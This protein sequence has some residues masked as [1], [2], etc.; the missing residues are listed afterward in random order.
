V[1]WINFNPYSRFELTGTRDDDFDSLS[2]LVPR[3]CAKIE[4]LLDEYASPTRIDIPEA[5]QARYSTYRPTQLQ[6][7]PQFAEALGFRGRIFC[8]REDS[9]TSGSHKLNSAIPE[10]YFAVQDGVEE[11]VVHTGAGQWGLAVALACRW[12]GIRATVFMT[13][14]S[15]EDKQERVGL[16]RMLGAQV[17]PSPSDETSTGRMAR[18]SCPEGSLAIALSEAAEW[19]EINTN[20]RVGQGCLSYHASLFQSV[21]GA[22]VFDQFNA[23]GLF[24]DALVAPVGGGTNFL[25][26]VSGYL[27]PRRPEHIPLLVA[28]EASEVPVL[29]S[30][31]LVRES[32]DWG[33]HFA[34][35]FMYSL[36]REHVAADIE[37][38]GLR[39]SVRSPLLSL[40]RRDGLVEPFQVN[41]RDA[42]EA[43]RLLYQSEG[44]LAAPESAIGV[45]AVARIARNGGS[46]N[47]RTIALNIS[48]SGLLDLHAYERVFARAVETQAATVP[49]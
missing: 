14:H 45:G 2:R 29:G 9:A 39:V 20:A 34:P 49:Q 46:R 1:Q 33:N 47:L 16:M 38:N 30:G 8:K 3:E 19:C 13:R 37:A 18:N 25:G 12:T 26:F 21:V 6:E 4:C 28:A 23:L 24:P 17:I 15:F 22:E 7:V 40:L 35:A 48:G 43:A 42:F 32:P 44:I 10:A 5:I 31:K 11:L 36:G 27:H 41:Q